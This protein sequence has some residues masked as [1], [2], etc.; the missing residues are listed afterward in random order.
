[1][2]F[3]RQKDKKFISLGSIEPKFYALLRE[4]AGLTDEIF[5]AQNDAQKWPEMK[6]K[7]G[8]IIKKTR[9]EWDAILAAMM[10]AMRLF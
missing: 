8:E 9:D 4:K 7:L 10:C 5:D 2:M 6:Q 1:M 3:M